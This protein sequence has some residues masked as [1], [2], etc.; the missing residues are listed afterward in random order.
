MYIR[1]IY[2]AGRYLIVKNYTPAVFPSP[3]R[4]SRE[5]PTTESRRKMNLKKK[6]EKIQM[7]IL[8]NFDKG[9]HIILEYPRDE[10]PSTY[11]EAEKNLV[12]FLRKMSRKYKTQG[13]QFRYLAVTERGKKAAALHH[14][15]ICENIPGLAEDI[16]QEW[17]DHVKVFKMY[18]EGC[19]KDLAE[20]FVKAETKEELTGAKNSYHRSR[21]LKD[22]STR[23]ELKSG[24]F[25]K[26]PPVPD[27]FKMIDLKNGYNETVGVRYQK[28]IL[29]W[30]GDNEHKEEQE[31]PKEPHK[32]KGEPKK[33]GIL[34]EIR[35]K[36]RSLLNR[37]RGKR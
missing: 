15:M 23:T 4:K 28:Y 12:K 8:A 30:E 7:L 14:H 19:Y 32:P 6:A 1:K 10:K 27:S 29:E 5:K 13:M 2:G 17:G 3:V 36:G 9:L 24:S 34:G 31:N 20:Y 25:P 11:E 33:K 16:F 35:E 26:E 21:N 18:K 22:I 37:I